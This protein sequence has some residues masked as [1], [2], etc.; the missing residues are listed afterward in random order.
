M[1]ATINSSGTRSLVAESAM[2]LPNWSHTRGTVTSF[3]AVRG[4][5]LPTIKPTRVRRQPTP[6]YIERGSSKERIDWSKCMKLRRPSSSG[7]EVGLGA[8]GW[9]AG[10][11]EVPSTSATSSASS[12]V[13]IGVQML[14]ATG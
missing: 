13:P 3:P 2:N 6:P 11:Q 10:P 4:K 1:V 14:A 8:A 9:T 12:T 7:S 5:L